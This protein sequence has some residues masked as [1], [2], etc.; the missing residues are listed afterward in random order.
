MRM[1][2]ALGLSA[3][4]PEGLWL[5]DWARL[6]P[7]LRSE[8]APY[9]GLRPFR[10]SDVEFYHGRTHEARRLSRAI[11]TLRDAGRVGVVALVGASGTGKSSVLAAGLAGH[12]CVDGLLAGWRVRFV[13]PE[14][15]ADA[16]V[17]VDLVVVDQFEDYLQSPEA[18]RIEAMEALR[19]HASERLV[20]VALRSDAFAAA[21]AEPTLTESLGRAVLVSP[22]TRAELRE[23]IVRPAEVAGVRVDDDLAHILISD[24]APGAETRQVPADVLPLLSNALLLIWAAGSGD[25]MTIADYR[26]IGGAAGAIE[27]LAE[28]VYAGLDSDA[29]LVTQ[30]LFLRLLGIAH[31]VVVCRSVPLADLAGDLPA[32]MDAFVSARMLTVSDDSVRISHEALLRHWTRLAGWVEEHR[33][34]LDSLAKLRRAAELWRD[35]EQDPN[36]LIPVQRLPMFTEWL[37]DTDRRVLL[38]ATERDFLAASEAHFASA[39]DKE[40][41]MS[42]RLRR[43]RRMAL[44]LAVAMTA[45]A[46]VAGVSYARGEGFRSE[47]VTARNEAESRQVAVA[48]TSL[49]AKSPNLQAQL[50]L[51]ANQLADTQEARS[52]VMDAASID[53]PTRWLG[54]PA[55]TLAVS[56]D[57]DLVARADGAGSVTLWRGSEL[58]LDSGTSFVADPAS[59]ALSS[60]AITEAGGRLL[61]AVAGSGVRSLWDVT[62]EP[63]KLADLDSEGATAVAFN[64]EGS[65]VA[66]GDAKGGATVYDISTPNHPAKIAAVRPAGADVQTYAVAIGGTDTLYVAGVRG[67]VNRWRLSATPKELARLPVTVAGPDGRL[68]V[69]AQALALSSDGTQLAAG[70][71]GHEVARWRI[72]AGGLAHPEAP[73]T[74]F[75]DIVNGVVFSRDGESIAVVSSDQSVE[76]FATTT[77][78]LQRKMYASSIQTGVGFAAA[79]QP[80]SAGKDG[81]L[82]VWPATSPL[83]KRSGAV[84]Y[85]L[86]TEGTEWLAGGSSTDGIALWHLG[87]PP[88][89]MPTPV[90]PKLAADDYQVGAVA[91]APSGR[92]L[93]GSSMKGEVLS[94]PLTASGVGTGRGFDSGLGGSVIF[95]AVAPDSTLVAA[96]SQRAS[97]VVLFRATADGVLARLSSIAVNT[98]QLVGFSA[99]GRLVAIAQ[100]DNRVALWSVQDPAKPVQVG[101]IGGLGST[102]T[103]CDMAPLTERIAIGESSGRVSVWDISDPSHPTEQRSWTDASSDIYSME[104]SRDEHQLI[105]TSGDDV[106]WGWRLDSPDTHADF[107]LNGEIGRPWDVRFLADGNHFAGSG[108]IGAVRIWDSSPELAR[109]SL[110]SRIGDML[111]AEEW[112]RYLPGIQPRKVC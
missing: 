29:Q 60:V 35:T 34:E 80:V 13:T 22:L 12:E 52:A 81:S 97:R 108:D 87:E 106:V 58:T 78:S 2:D 48:A 56:P 109:Q 49:R 75:S 69:R 91:V 99:D 8:R 66:F 77:G 53:V 105:G 9:V 59:G 57:G 45:T 82:L 88:R 28:S 18:D 84:I 5:D 31:D 19:R 24:L 63:A 20:V 27:T 95:T 102:P 65:R 68:P 6:R 83:W 90:P 40:R 44:G 23:V 70:L 76:V 10:G 103:S 79:G 100:V 3:D 26:K 37:D 62:G 73:L 72:G 47:A 21:V 86:S 51:V 43:Q 64:T 39:L 15:I 50:A 16:C 1:V 71:A 38:G 55:A 110:C 94:W 89:R 74:A 32:V 14:T 101:V 98:P 7:R 61:L 111:T 46:L 30:R 54:K 36:V 17:D 92:Y 4:L 85:N 11:L 93:L 107:A 67:E 42:R 104:F 25:R 112:R 96:M 41:L 33:T